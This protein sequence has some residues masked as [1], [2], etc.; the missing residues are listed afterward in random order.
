MEFAGEGGEE[1]S[2]MNSTLDME[3]TG[4]EGEEVSSMNSTLDVKFKGEGESERSGETK[5]YEGLG[6]E[7]GGMSGAILYVRREEMEGAGDREGGGGES[8]SRSSK[9]RREGK[10]NCGGISKNSAHPRIGSWRKFSRFPSL[11]FPRGTRGERLVSNVLP[12]AIRAM[13]ME[14]RLGN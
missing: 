5:E 1:I 6:R 12:K 8:G 10:G 14:S 7:D 11:G 9:I 4:E 3:F 2:S 13:T